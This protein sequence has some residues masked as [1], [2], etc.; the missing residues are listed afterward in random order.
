MMT[1]LN[2]SGSGGGGMTPPLAATE[3]CHH[4]AGRR[5]VRAATEERQQAGAAEA[6]A[7][8][9]TCLRLDEPGHG[10][11]PRTCPRRA[12]VQQQVQ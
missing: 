1:H 3:T 6:E 11:L 8:R 7:D 4:P 12:G 2:N 10:T 5:A 9:Q